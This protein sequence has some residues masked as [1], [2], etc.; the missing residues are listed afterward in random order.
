MNG[1]FRP[2]LA[3]LIGTFALIFIGAGSICADSFTRGGVGLVGIALAHG[4]TIAVMVSAT[5]HISGGHLNPAVTVG[6][7]VGGKI[8]AG[9]A[10]A[11]ILS[12]LVGGVLGGLALKGIFPAEAWRAVHLGT[13]DLAASVSYGTGTAMEL[14]LT[15]F[16]VF[17]VFAT[18]I[19]P[20]GAFKMI[21]GLAIGFVVSFDILAGGP[22][23]GA[24]MNPARTFGPALA[25]GHW[26]HHGVYWIGPLLGGAIAG[27]LYKSV[28]LSKKAA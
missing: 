12:Q 26:S 4:L 13:P 25:A 5:G 3:E 24:S 20:R 16:L 23:T 10:L 15:F 21:A 1:I 8:S 19:D 28:Y 6:A 14:I 11:Y 17:T 7:L 9:M 18:A 22:L 2:C 27:G